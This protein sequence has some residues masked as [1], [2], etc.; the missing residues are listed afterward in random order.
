MDQGINSFFSSVQSLANSP[1]VA[2]QTNVVNSATALSSQISSL[3]SSLYGLQFQSDGDISNAVSSVNADL[4]TL[5]TLNNTLERTAATNQSTAGLLDQRDAAL[6]DIAQYMD[7]K[8]TFQEDGEVTVTTTGGTTLLT[9]NILTQLSYS[10]VSGTQTLINNNNLS[11]IQVSTLDANGNPIGNPVNLTTSGTASSITTT[12]KSGKIQ[13]LLSIRD[14]VIP[15]ILSQ[16]DQLAS[17]LR[18]QTNAI[19]NAGTSSPPPNSYTGTR[20]TSGSSVSQYSGN[21]QIAVLD[22]NGNP[23]PSP[24]ADEPNG[25]QPLTLNL[26]TLNTGLGAGKDSVDGIINSINQ[27]Y[28]P[29]NKAEIGN[30]NNVQLGIASTTVPATGNSLNLD[31]N[32][33]NI[34]SSNANF[35]VTGMTVLDNNNATVD[36]LSA[37]SAGLGVPSVALSSYQATGSNTITVTTSGTNTLQDGQTVYLGAPTTP[38]TVGGVSS[39]SFSGQYYTVSNVS[40]NSFDITVAGVTTAVPNTPDAAVSATGA[41]ALPPYDSVGSGQNSNTLGNGAITADLS[42]NSTSPYYTV[43]ANIATV[44]SSGNVVTSTVSYRVPNNTSG[45]MNNL[46]GATSATGNATLVKPSSTQPLAVASLVDANGNPLPLVNGSYGNEQGYLQIKAGNST[47][48]IAVNELDSQQ[49]GLPNDTPPQAG[50]NQGFSQYFGLNNF[51]NNN[52]LTSTGDTLHNSALN[53]S[54]ASNIVNNPGL[55]STGTLSQSNQPTDST[56]PPNFTYQ[57][58]SGDNS[59]SQQL[60]ALATSLTA[61]SSAGGMPSSTTTFSQYAGQI[62]AL[63]SANSASATSTMNNSQTLLNGFTTAAQAVSGVNLDQELANTVIYQNAYTAST[64]VITVVGQLF[65]ELMGIIQ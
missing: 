38:T 33:G 47:Q 14:S 19:T 45:S 34:S 55:I 13:G 12:L 36:T 8:P 56:S 3:A 60:A 1:S 5:H 15:N 62:I 65:T 24:Y 50:T 6:N 10:P 58:S 17:T 52:S 53:L 25:V 42:I 49:L 41:T 57:V 29:Q 16:L 23:I 54:V 31:F 4:E 59:N 44:D 2:A 22:T 63:T 21:V 46:I 27:Y 11:A 26:A 39:T 32:L 9:N 48:T 7:I 37:G 40:G 28:T 18:D 61:Y 35:Y 20:L 43:Q 51:F 30:I 64:R